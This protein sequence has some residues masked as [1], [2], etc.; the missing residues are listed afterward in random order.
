MNANTSP[1]AFY[2]NKASQPFRAN[3][4]QKEIAT[5]CGNDLPPFYI[6]NVDADAPG[7]CELYDANTDEKVADLSCSPHLLTHTTTIDGKSVK[8]WI[9]QGTQPGIFGDTRKGYYYLKIGQYYSDIFVIG[10]L[11]AN[12]VKLEWQIFDDIITTDGSLISKY[13]VY[14]Q[15]FAVPLWHP[16]YSLEEEGKTNNGIYF[17]TQ[18][19]TRKTSG[20][21]TIVNEAQCDLLSLIAPVADS[22]QITSCINGQVREMRTNRFEMTSKWQSD[23]VTH[24]ECEFD[25]FTIIR[26]YQKSEDAP[27]PLPIP[28]PPAPISNYY[29]RGKAQSGISSIQLNIN[30]STQSIPVINGEFE[31]GYDVPI[32]SLRTST[33]S[34]TMAADTG[35]TNVDKITE[36]DFSESDGFGTATAVILNQLINCTTINLGGCQFNNL[37]TI[38]KM[39]DGDSA[40]TSVSMPAATFASVIEGGATFRNCSNLT[41]VNMQ[42]AELTIGSAEMFSGCSQLD[43]VD[44]RNS[45]FEDDTTAEEMFYGVKYMSASMRFDAATF[46]SVTDCTKMFSKANFDSSV[47]SMSRIFPSWSAKPTIAESMFEQSNP[48]VYMTISAIDFSLCENFKRFVYNSTQRIAMDGVNMSSGQI[49]EST[50]EL[51]MLTTADHDWIATQTFAAAIVTKNMFKKALMF[52]SYDPTFTN[53]VFANVTNAEGMFESCESEVINLPIATFASLTNATNMFKSCG[54]LITANLSAATFAS[55]TSTGGIFAGC[56]KLKNINVP[57]AATMPVGFSLSQS[58]LLLVQSL[59][60]IAQW[61]KDLTGLQAQQIV[62]N[63]AAVN[64]WLS[65]PDTALPFGAAKLAIENKNWTLQY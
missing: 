57:N 54:D 46:A 43:S 51:H 12:Y 25:L 47:D 4:R 1:I 35:L 61:V 36:L 41:S 62:L 40:L 3:Y 30:G 10:E 15:I 48:A 17:A 64:G 42:G 23:D 53:A 52:H 20:F 5:I 38:R 6:Y 7:T 22:I 49:F 60:N 59:V 39:F 26:K 44:L 14:K 58:S 13:V 56:G 65:N 33:N 24:I 29:I 16:E 27:E 32:T 2:M 55:L 21:S 9:F 37:T 50:F 45:T 18:Q 8:M 31:F 11:P 34:G 19:T 63:T 28:T